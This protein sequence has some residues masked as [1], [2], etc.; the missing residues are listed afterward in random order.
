M[1]VK[2]LSRIT[3]RRPGVGVV[4]TQTFCVSIKIV[5]FQEL[6][7]DQVEKGHTSL[8]SMFRFNFHTLL[9]ITTKFT[10]DC[11]AASAYSFFTAVVRIEMPLAK[12]AITASL[13]SEEANH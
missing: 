3:P 10:T 2:L 11:A 13:L 7:F 8:L 9:Q 1:N 5:G 6:L 12:R 4:L